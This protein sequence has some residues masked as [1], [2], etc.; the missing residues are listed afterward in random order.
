VDAGG[1]LAD[2]Q[3]VGDLAVRPAL[4]DQGQHLALALGQPEGS[5]ACGQASG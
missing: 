1:V 4:G 2:E 5:G 3:L